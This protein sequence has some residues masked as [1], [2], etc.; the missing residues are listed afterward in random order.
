MIA[1]T[2]NKHELSSL[3]LCF[4]NIQLRIFLLEIIWVEK[5]S[6]VPQVLTASAEMLWKICFGLALQDMRL[7][8]WN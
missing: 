4:G 7:V 6:L 5:S 8:I 3:V 1:P 2:Q